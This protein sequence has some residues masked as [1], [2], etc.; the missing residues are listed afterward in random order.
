MPMPD[1]IRNSKYYD[2]VEK[3]Q[4]YIASRCQ[5]LQRRK[6]LRPYAVYKFKRKYI[7]GIPKH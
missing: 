5:K 7:D 4:A 6:L 2:L 1:R 3:K